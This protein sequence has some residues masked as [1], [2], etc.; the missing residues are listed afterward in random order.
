[1]VSEVC[2]VITEGVSDVEVE[3]AA[4]VLLGR[5]GS[6]VDDGDGAGE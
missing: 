1:M 3:T 2:V 6:R 4:A 5:S